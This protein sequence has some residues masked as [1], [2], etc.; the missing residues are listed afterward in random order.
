MPPIPR[1]FPRFAAESPQEGLPQG[2]W[3]QVLREELVKAVGAIEDLPAGIELP[4]AI[5]WFPERAWGTRVYVP[6]TARP[7]SADGD[8]ELFGYVSFERA[9]GTG[10]PGGFHASA[11]FT[12]VVAEA[13]PD[14]KIDLNDE[15]LSPWR[16]SDGATGDMTLIWGRP[17]IAGAVAATAELDG[18]PVDQVRLDEDRFTLVAIDAVKGLG[19]DLFVEVTLWSKRGQELAAESLYAEAEPADSEAEE[20]VNPPE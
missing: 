19:D 12:D 11:D 18:E 13:N 20:G 2:R 4:E 16:N 17:L 15:V 7:L 5:T 14:W 10:A 8:V 3:A 6:A 9:P 1:S